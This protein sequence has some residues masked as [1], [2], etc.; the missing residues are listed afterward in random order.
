MFLFMSCGRRKTGWRSFTALSAL[1]VLA[2]FSLSCNKSGGSL[3]IIPVVYDTAAARVDYSN[4]NRAVFFD[5][6]SGKITEVPH[7]FFDIAFYT[8]GS[9]GGGSAPII[10]NSGSYGSGVWVYDTGLGGANIADDFS[11]QQAEIKQYTF[12]E[13]APIYNDGP[14]LYQ[15]KVRSEERR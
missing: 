4:A 6:S 12:S 15:T 5:F 3:P 14:S 9:G 8:V 7:D 2:V 13:N 1:V 10:A 11:G